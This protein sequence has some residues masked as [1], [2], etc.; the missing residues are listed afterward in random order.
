[1]AEWFSH[2]H[3]CWSS[4]A[5]S[6]LIGEVPDA[7]KDGGQKEGKSSESEMAG[8]HHRC[9]GHEVGQTSG[10][11]EGQ[12]GLSCLSPWG[13]KVSDTTGQQ[14]NRVFFKF[15]SHF[16]WPQ[17]IEQSSLCY[18]VGLCWLSALN[19]AAW[20]CWSQ[21]LNLSLPH[22]FFL[23]TRHLFFVCESVYVL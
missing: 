6:W 14:S 19:I 9:N 2:T 10:D 11:G 5:S 15:F 4:D 13:C 3:T 22:P 16:G 1:M 7:G 8:Q 20:T 18:T 17:N 21:S 23:V 12:G